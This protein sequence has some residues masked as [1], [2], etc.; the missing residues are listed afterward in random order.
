VAERFRYLFTVAVN[1]R[2]L[3]DGDRQLRRHLDTNGGRLSLLLEVPKPFF[4][5]LSVELCNTMQCRSYVV[6]YG[7]APPTKISEFFI[8]QCETIL[9]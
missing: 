2:V 7:A 6:A 1:H 4:T 3:A 9:V 5:M 8:E